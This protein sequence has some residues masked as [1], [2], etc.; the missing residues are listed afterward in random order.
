M[1]FALGMFV[2]GAIVAFLGWAIFRPAARAH[3]PP[4]RPNGLP[5]T[6]AWKDTYIKRK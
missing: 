2:G 1:E 3:L 6:D 5:R 4:E